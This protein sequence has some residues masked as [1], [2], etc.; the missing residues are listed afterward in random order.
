MD[1]LT[2]ALFPLPTVLFPGGTIKLKIFE[3][4][5]LDMTKRCISKDEGFGLVCATGVDSFSSVGTLMTIRE[6]D[7]PHTGIFTL[8][9]VG[10]AR[11]VVKETWL[12]KDGLNRATVTQ[13]PDETDV[14]LPSEYSHLAQLIEGLVKQFGEDRFPQPLELTSASWVG[15]R[16][17]EVVPLDLKVKQQLLEVSDPVLRL[18]AVAQFL[19][20]QRVTSR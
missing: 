18:K 12:E 14:T 15:A 8:D 7:M 17:A 3:Q 19:E 16:L 6:W 10:A 2:I 5:Y 11:F 9:T 4:R 1:S 20:Q 13:I